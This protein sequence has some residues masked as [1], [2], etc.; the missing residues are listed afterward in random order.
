M[1]ILRLSIMNPGKKEQFFILIIYY[2]N[3]Y[4]SSLAHPRNLDLFIFGNLPTYFN[5]LKIIEPKVFS[6]NHY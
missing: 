6:E 2:E 1:T 5:V 4:K 3:W